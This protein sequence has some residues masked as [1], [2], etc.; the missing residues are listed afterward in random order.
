MAA[1]ESK[2]RFVGYKID[3]I[4]LNMFPAIQILQHSALPPGNWNIG[5]K[6][7]PPQFFTD[8]KLYIGGI[9]CNL[10][11]HVEGAP[12]EA[13]SQVTMNIGIAGSFQVSERFTE[14]H[15]EESLVKIQMPLLLF[16][17]LRGA[18]TSILANSG[19]GTLI[20]PLVNLH[21]LA[22]IQ[23]A[24]T[25]IEIVEPKSTSQGSESIS[26]STDPNV[27]TVNLPKSR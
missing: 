17:Y 4:A 10:Q 11:F 6:I 2:F 3:S 27:R 16:P 24:S 22:K 19:Y 21:E 13:P 9:D 5:L 23:L 20:M 26:R 7:R 15:I 1:I 12:S 14:K 8:S 25:Q 18:I